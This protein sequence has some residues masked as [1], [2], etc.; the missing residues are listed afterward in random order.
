M[1]EIAQIIKTIQFSAADSF[2][3]T[4]MFPAASSA[5]FMISVYPNV[6]RSPASQF[7]QPYMAVPGLMI[8]NELHE[9]L[10]NLES[11]GIH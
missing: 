10:P 8:I 7:T 4:E 3:D 6:S 5:G 2:A 9:H 1:T 11:I